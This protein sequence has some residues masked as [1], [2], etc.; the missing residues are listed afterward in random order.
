MSR[1]N[2]GA[3]LA[4]EVLPGG[5]YLRRV[6]SLSMLSGSPTPTPCGRTLSVGVDALVN[7]LIV[8]LLHTGRSAYMLAYVRHDC[9]SPQHVEKLTKALEHVPQ[10]VKDAQRSGSCSLPVA[11]SVLVPPAESS[12]EAGKHLLT[13]TG[14]AASGTRPC[15]PPSR[16][17]HCCRWP[18]PASVALSTFDTPAY[19]CC[20]CS[21]TRSR[22]RSPACGV[23]GAGGG[24]DG[25]GGAQ[26]QRQ[27]GCEG[28]ASTW[29]S[30]ISRGAP[31][32]TCSTSSARRGR[33]L[34]FCN[35]LVP[36]PFLGVQWSG[37]PG[38]R[39]RTGPNRDRLPTPRQ[40]WHAVVVACG[41]CV[42]S[43]CSCSSSA[44]TA[45]PSPPPLTFPSLTRSAVSTSGSPH[46]CPEMSRPSI[47]FIFVFLDRRAVHS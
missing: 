37:R 28:P 24:G 17:L 2:H 30:L 34:A 18:G 14:V 15:S 32:A 10:H 31:W 21:L 20:I 12:P 5:T 39:S 40:P 46:S 3:P 35:A 8:R 9:L 43:L 38:G 33:R 27:G 36:K 26:R 11:L 25:G 23:G 13:T 16:Q 44:L 4:V 22:S 47:A 6:A 7:K 42:S 29:Q 45:G 1:M 19:P 41:H